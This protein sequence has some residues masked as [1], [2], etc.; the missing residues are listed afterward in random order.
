M[1]IPRAVIALAG[2]TG[3]GKTSIV[4]RILGD[5]PEHVAMLSHDAYY[6]NNVHLSQEERARVNYD[7]PD[8]LDQELFI[9][10]VCELKAGRT[11]E[12]PVYNFNRHLRED[13]TRRL[14]PQA[15]LL[16]EGILVLENPRLRP[17]FDLKIFVDTDAD[18]RI[19]RRITRD[20]EERGRTLQSVV[21]QYLETVKPMH[22]AFVEPTKRYAD[23]IIPEGALNRPGVDV[24]MARIRAFLQE[25]AQTVS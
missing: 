6:R 12:A 20:I 2:G 5:M 21:Q 19:L 3:S 23:I 9:H 25:H 1:T 11:I 10:H 15:I 8:S 17:L 18:V 24:L 22:E 4:Q 13:F 16:V 7:H 14:A